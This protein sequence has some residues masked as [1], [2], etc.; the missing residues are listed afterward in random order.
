MVGIWYVR[1][2]GHMV[3]IVRSDF[4]LET[5]LRDNDIW[6][7]T[8]PNTRVDLTLPS[9][10]TVKGTAITWS[11]SEGNFG[12]RFRMR[13]GTKWIS[14]PVTSSTAPRAARPPP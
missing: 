12:N 14:R 3:G 9:G 6:G 13:P 2:D 8:T 11:D 1:P 5:E 7:R 10:G 4:R